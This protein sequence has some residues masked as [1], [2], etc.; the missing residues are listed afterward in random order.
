MF[1]AKQI[2][3]AALI[4]LALIL[5]PALALATT[6]AYTAQHGHTDSIV[7]AILSGAAA[8]GLIGSTVTYRFQPQGTTVAVSSTTAPT[9]IQAAGFNGLQAIV[10]MADADTSATIT[11]NWGKS[12]ND[13]TLLYPWVSLYA[14]VSG[15]IF[16]QLAVDVSNTNAVVITK[17]TG[18]GS[19]GTYV[20]RLERPHSI[21][22]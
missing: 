7:L 11:H 8:L 17:T 22:S 1:N 15:T 2:R 12:T 13:V 16:P 21:V 4:A 18:V 5:L 3:S 6:S 19:A 9:A 14:Q 20:V 10:G